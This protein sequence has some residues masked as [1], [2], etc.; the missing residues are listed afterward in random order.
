ML[1]MVRRNEQGMTLVEV[2]AVF[3]IG[4]I[5]SVIAV[6]I[7]L[8]GYRS[9]ER[10]KTNV[11]LRDSADLIMAHL[12]E[13]LYTLKVSEIKEFHTDDG[14][15][16]VLK[17]TEEK[18]GIADGKVII[19]QTSYPIASSGVRIRHRSKITREKDGLFHITLVLEKNGNSLHLESEIGIINDIDIVPKE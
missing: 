7:L 6:Q 12:V 2:L 3:V 9:Y 13:E 8:N 5:I 10:T 11:E 17:D 15:Y 4:A 19:K 16:I 14:F 1:G 18:I